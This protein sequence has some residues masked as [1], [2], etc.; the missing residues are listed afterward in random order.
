M[1]LYELVYWPCKICYF[2]LWKKLSNAA[3]L[4]AS[5]ETGSFESGLKGTGMLLNGLDLSCYQTLR[6]DNF[7]ITQILLFL[8]AYICDPWGSM[9]L[10]VSTR[11]CQV[12]R[13]P[14]PGRKTILANT[15]ATYLCFSRLNVWTLDVLHMYGYIGTEVFT[16]IIL[17]SGYTHSYL[18]LWF[19]II[20]IFMVTLF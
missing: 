20:C 12:Y 10:E 14:N 2:Y 9:T 1:P 18:N 19:S 16:R 5:S 15:W 3:I 11:Y 6:H 4:R 8:S 13:Q 17:S 7:L